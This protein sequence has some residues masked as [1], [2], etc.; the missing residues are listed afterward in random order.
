MTDWVCTFDG[1][2]EPA[3]ARVATP[4]FPYPKGAGLG[5]VTVYPPDSKA[6]TGM[7]YCLDHAH[8]TVDMVLMNA[9]PG[10]TP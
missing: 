6:A 8:L 7:P 4:L 1:C 5:F 9:L 3:K 2:T 10:G